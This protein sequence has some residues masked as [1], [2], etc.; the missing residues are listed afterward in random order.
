M[1]SAIPPRVSLFKHA[2]GR[3]VVVQIARVVA[4]VVRQGF[5]H[6]IGHLGE[7]ARR[8]L[9][10]IPLSPGRI[11]RVPLADQQISQYAQTAAG[12]PLS[13][14]MEFVREVGEERPDVRACLRRRCCL[15]IGAVHRYVP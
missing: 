9:D 4:G 8:P 2:G 11:A 13:P 1:M 6:V 7:V 14:R 12:K 10:A 15:M 3:N 5:V